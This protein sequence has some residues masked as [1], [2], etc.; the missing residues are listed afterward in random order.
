MRF[1]IDKNLQRVAAAMV[2][3]VPMETI[4]IDLCAKMID[5]GLIDGTEGD[6]ITRTI[7]YAASEC[8]IAD[9]AKVLADYLGVSSIPAD[10][11]E[12]FR[13]V[14]IIGDGDCPECGGDL[15]FIETDGHDIPSGDRDIPPGYEIDYYVYECR[16]C[17][18]IIKSEIEL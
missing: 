1:K 3:P 15:R 16:E 13:N 5:A 17:G 2:A 12:S 10:V 8:L 9:V 11:F 18:K 4:A 6:N 7:S 14:I